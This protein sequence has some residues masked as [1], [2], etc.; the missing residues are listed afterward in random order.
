MGAASAPSRD[1]ESGLL[2][3][4]LSRPNDAMERARAL[5]AARPEPLD[6]SVAHQAIGLVLREFGDIDASVRE[7]RTALRLARRSGVADREA[8][9][10]GT[11]GVA[12][13]FAGQT[14]AGRNAL[15]AAVGAST[16]LLRGRALLRRGACLLFLGLHGPALDDLNAAIPVLRAADDQIWEARALTQ[17][18]ECSLT[19]GSVRPAAADLRRAEAL[20][21]A[22][23][24]ELE[25]A[26]AVMHRGVVA[27]RLGDLPAALA[28]FDEA[29]ERYAALGVT[30]PDL[31]AYRCAALTAAGLASD[32]LREADAAVRQLSAAGGRP[33]KRAEL[34]LVAAD[35]ALAAREPGIANDRAAEA[36]R[37]FSR[38]RRRWW[39]AHARLARVRAEVGL[40]HEPPTVALLQ[41]ARRC[42]RELAEIGSPDLP[43]ARLTAGRVALGLAAAAGTGSPSASS[44]LTLAPAPDPVPG[45][46]RSRADAWLSEA[47]AWLAAAAAERGRGP[48]LS[49]AVAWLAQAHRA[50][51]AGDTRNLMH[52]CRRGLAVIDDYRSVFGSTE[53][54]A[55]STAHGAELAALG[56]LH[57]A[58]L[59]RPWLMLEWS[60]R[61]RAVALAVPAVRPPDDEL[62]QADLAALR[63]VTSRLAGTRDLG[64][65]TAPLEQE[66]QRLERAVRARS[67]HAAAGRKRAPAPHRGAPAG[68]GPAGGNAAMRPARAPGPVSR[69]RRG[70]PSDA[71]R[72][73]SVHK[74]LD[75]LGDGRLIELIDVGGE[76]H[77]LVCGDGRV[78]RITVGPAEAATRA[79]Q[80]ARLALR[81]VAHGPPVSPSDSVVHDW[82][83]AMGSQL[84]RELLGQAGDLLGDENVV[85]VP[86]GRLHAVPWGLLPGSGRGRSAS[87]PRPLP[88]CGRGT[89]ASV[90]RPRPPRPRPPRDRRLPTAPWYLSGDRAWPPAGP[91]FPGSRP[92]TPAGRPAVPDR[93]CSGAGPRRWRPSCRRST[94]PG[95][96]TSRRTAR[97]ARTARCSP[98]SVSTMAR[99]RS[100]TWS[101]CAAGPAAWCCQAATPASPPRLAR[102][103]CSAWPA[104]S[105]P[106]VPPE[107]WPAWCRSMTARSSR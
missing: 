78:Q 1:G 38:Q 59:G 22:N 68:N 87:P 79:V 58:K 17:R 92:I 4:A 11:L 25:S 75:A 60:E 74:L 54:R 3:L 90:P 18:S 103:R 34:I 88:G 5:L 93:W 43:L 24:Q 50:E 69:R 10:L 28:C 2:A 89:R 21:A 30:E 48:A 53:L 40:E 45:F 70:G 15:N 91:K 100:M 39:R 72:G 107:S 64:L 56:Q 31:T 35:C 26:D 47:D 52:A 32:A 6:A 12:L 95:S 46:T 57:A 61:W 8:D 23:G 7:L 9:V 27:F 80:F 102:T 67:L 104:R 73:F 85:I 99:S 98:R 81:R 14:R 63:D 84:D 106:S 20:Y 94:A 86:P 16:G 55:Q 96:R 37:L 49:R 76:V 62:L 66:R 71:D 101:G 105:S 44:A 77:A 19:M 29:A 13:V 97:S 65:P 41:D 33:T 42:V 51:A 83:A 36:A 82:L